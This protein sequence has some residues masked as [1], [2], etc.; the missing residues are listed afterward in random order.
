MAAARFLDVSEEELESNK[1]KENA[2]TLI[3][4]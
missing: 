4:T 2:V 1:V 3:I